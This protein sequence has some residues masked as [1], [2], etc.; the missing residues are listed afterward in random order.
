MMRMELERE[1]LAQPVKALQHMLMRLSQVY[2]VLP[3]VAESGIFDTLV[4]LQR[5]KSWKMER[6][7]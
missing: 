6:M 4:I 1:V 2:D 7:K 5:D 3:T